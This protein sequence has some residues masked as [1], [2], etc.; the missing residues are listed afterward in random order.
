MKLLTQ[1]LSIMAVFVVVLLPPCA[2][3]ADYNWRERISAAIGSDFGDAD[4]EEEVLFGR[5]IAARI[6]AQYKLID[7]IRL[8]KYVTMTGRALVQ[9]TNRSE[10]QFH[11][12]VIASDELNAYSTPGGYVFVTSAALRS[13]GDEAEL[14]GVLAHEIAHISERH[15]VR[16]LQL[17]GKDKSS[18]ASLAVLIGGA[19]ET[20]GVAFNQ[21]V[22][23]AMEILFR[24]GYRR[25]DEI[26]ADRLATI[27]AA[28]AGYDPSAFL[29]Y[30][31]TVGKQKGTVGR[32]YPRYEQRQEIIARTIDTDGLAVTGLQ[33]HQER[34]RK[35]TG[36]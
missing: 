21:A 19:S 25:E 30:L 29:S 33:R 27:T 22:D 18:A 3:A 32:S 24:D 1:L 9:Q 20:A 11:F 12:A 14:A 36:K 13:M 26:Q 4:S 23:K 28:L 8:Q 6:L 34:F 7:D 31:E 10:L 2:E 35:V 16:E 15:I 5:E 17:R